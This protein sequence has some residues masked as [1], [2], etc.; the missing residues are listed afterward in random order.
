MFIVLTSANNSFA[1]EELIEASGSYIMDSRLD[2]TPASATARAR[3]EAKRNAI[4]QAGTYIETYSKMVDLE[5]TQDEVK[6]VAA[7]F[8]KIQE[9]SS[10]IKVIQDNLLEFTVT[11]KALVDDNNESVLKTIMQDKQNLEELT[12][13][14]TELQKQYDELKRQMEDLKQQYN[15]ANDEEK[16]ILKQAVNQNNEYFNA[17]QELERGNEYYSRGD[18]VKALEFYN[19]AIQLN[20]QSAE[21]YNNRGNAYAALGQYE[22]AVQDLK[23]ASILANNRAEIH[24]NLGSVYLL[25]KLYNEAMQEYTT[26]IELNPN[27]AEAYYN[28]SIIYYYQ[29]RYNEALPDAKRALELDKNDSAIKDLYN[30]IIRKLN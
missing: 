8:L 15:S 24:N 28:R 18:Y 7:Q 14:N 6:T 22:K 16:I 30:K 1:K 5:L 17:V 12:R 3:E 10:H 2:E 4:E 27:Y 9:E 26:A 19:H 23:K 11:I 29:A 25:L 20:P 21:I 13:R